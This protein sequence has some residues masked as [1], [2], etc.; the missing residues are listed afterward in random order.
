MLAELKTI[1]VELNTP[2]TL[3]QASPSARGK[4]ILLVEDNEVAV[5]Q[6]RMA[7]E[8]EGYIVDAAPGG[9]QALAHVKHTIPD[10]IILD[11]MMPE[12][13]GFEVLEAIRSTEATRRIPV[14]IL[15]AKELTPEDHSRLSVNNIQEL[16]QKGDVDRAELLRKVRQMMGITTAASRTDQGRETVSPEPIL[17]ETPANPFRKSR[18][19]KPCVLIVEDHPDNMMSLKAVLSPHYRILEATDGQ[20]GL[21]MALEQHPEVIIVDMA[22]PTMDGLTVVRRLRAE[23]VGKQ[24]PVLA[25]TAQAMKG[26]REKILTAGCNDYMTKPFDPQALLD[27]LARWVTND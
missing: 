4:R 12:V 20:V 2:N 21:T 22:L 13:N 10:G 26:D 18:P 17:P 19:G 7:L 11:L 8:K 15:T 23:V 6:V 27:T 5:I 14:L 24:V 3:P 16:V 9:Q 25:L 1:L